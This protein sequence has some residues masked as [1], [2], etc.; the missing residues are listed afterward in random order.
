MTAQTSSSD[1]HPKTGA[2][3]TFERTADADNPRYA[4]HIYL[5][6]GRTMECGL[7]WSGPR[8]VLTG[9]VSDDDATL[10]WARDEALK[11]ARVLKN[12]GQAR[13]SRWRG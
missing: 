12:S 11:L 3:F 10:Q 7:E 2:R 13:L 1:L 6:D 9:A 8:A 4:V 5:A